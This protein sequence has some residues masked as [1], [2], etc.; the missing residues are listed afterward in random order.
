[1]TTPTNKPA[2]LSNLPPALQGAL[3][4][5][6]LPQYQYRGVTYISERTVREV[7]EQDER[8]LR[9]QIQSNPGQWL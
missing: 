4:P 8:A 9:Q 7:R 3:A 1:M 2:D 5:F 6:V